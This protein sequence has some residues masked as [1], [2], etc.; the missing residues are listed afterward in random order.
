LLRYVDNGDQNNN[1]HA[2][3]DVASQ[4]S[5]S[6]KRFN[7]TKKPQFS[8]LT[9][10]LILMITKLWLVYRVFRSVGSQ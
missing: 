4:R 3:E 9:L 1:Q 5:Q 10:L 8:A 6:R 2:N 7:Q